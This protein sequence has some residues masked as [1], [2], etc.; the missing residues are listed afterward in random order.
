MMRMP[1]A[2]AKVYIAQGER[3]VGHRPDHVIP[4]IPRS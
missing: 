2:Q 3:A 1:D 4:P